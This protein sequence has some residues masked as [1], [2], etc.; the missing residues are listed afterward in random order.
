[1][2]HITRGDWNR[3]V[4]FDWICALNQFTW[5]RDL[6]LEGWEFMG[7]WFRTLFQGGKDL[8]YTDFEKR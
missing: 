1:M 5:D 6:E 2:P 4:W 3:D 8:G 7:E